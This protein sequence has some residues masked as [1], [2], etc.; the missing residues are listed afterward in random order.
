MGLDGIVNSTDRDNNNFIAQPLLVEVVGSSNGHK[1][2]VISEEPTIYGD[3]R[4]AI[5]DLN[6][7][8]PMGYLFRF[9]ISLLSGANHALH[10]FRGARLLKFL[11]AANDIHDFFAVIID[12]DLLVNHIKHKKDKQGNFKKD[13]NEKPLR[14]SRF[15]DKNDE[16]KKCSLIAN[17]AFLV[18]DIGGVFLLL[19][20][21]KLVSLAKVS[22]SIGNKFSTLAA[23]FGPRFAQFTSSVVKTAPFVTKVVAKLTLV[24]LIRSVVAGAFVALA[25]NDARRI[26]CAYEKGD[27]GKLI[28]CSLSCASYVTEIALQA[29]ALI[30]FSYVPVLVVL[31]GVA[32]GLGLAAFIM[33]SVRRYR[34][35]R[36]EYQQAQQPP[37]TTLPQDQLQPLNA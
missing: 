31:G 20:E 14:K 1:V 6:Q 4:K 15:L 26:Y 3:L 21:L 37:V 17:I 19:D 28:N 36:D 18:A 12:V 11:N 9:S 7:R 35:E 16:I 2:K 29:L 24:N 27:W 30:S 23:S 32:A 33:S 34:K 8:S 22:A 13:T 10:S 5:F 25:L